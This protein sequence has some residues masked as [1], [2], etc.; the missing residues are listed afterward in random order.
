MINSKRLTTR[1]LEE[2]FQKKLTLM[3]KLHLKKSSIVEKI[4]LKKK[5]DCKKS[6]IAKSAVY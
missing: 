3:K 1:L 2:R 5:Q 6:C 4:E